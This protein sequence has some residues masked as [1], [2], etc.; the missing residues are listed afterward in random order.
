VFYAL[1]RETGDPVWSYDTSQ[2]GQPAE[3]HGDPVV[4]EDVVVTGCD[5]TALAHTYAFD[6]NN[7]DLFWKQPAAAFA[8]DVIQVG[9]RAVGRRWNGDLMSLSIDDGQVQWILQPQDY[10]YRYRVDFSPVIFGD[11]IY[12]GGVD[13]FVHAVEGASGLTRWRRDLGDAI[14]TTP[15][16]DGHDLYVGV[17]GNM[18]HLLSGK[19]GTLLASQT[20]SGRPFG[21]PALGEEV[22]VFLIEDASLVAYDRSLGE[23]RWSKE[24][25]RT[26]SS[27]Q[28]LLWDGVLVLGTPGGEVIGYRLADG[29]TDF[30]LTVEG[31]VRGL[32]RDET[33][34]YIG[35]LGGTLYAWRIRD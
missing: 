20:C 32:G 35:T 8:S 3:F 14:T 25:E 9:D 29:S 23:V 15:V 4:V 6:R 16:T 13:G 31:V 12:Y 2:D 5:R 24:A 30:R 33:T 28:P 19:D 34:L 11:V 21:R 27:Y 22:V 18:I 26:W 7:G 10:T 17:A 1:D